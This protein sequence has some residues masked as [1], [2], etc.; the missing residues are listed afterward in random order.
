[1]ALFLPSRNRLNS[2]REL[3]PPPRNDHGDRQPAVSAAILAA[4]WWGIRVEGADEKART[5]RFKAHLSMVIRRS[6]SITA[7]RQDHRRRRVAN[8]PE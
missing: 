7:D 4:M 8:S 6:A 1:M 3:A 5:E 2:A